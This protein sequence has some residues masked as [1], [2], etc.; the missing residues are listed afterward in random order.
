MEAVVRGKQWPQNY[1]S[2]AREGISSE[3]KR[4]LFMTVECGRRW[5][6][7]Q[8]MWTLQNSDFLLIREHNG[9]INTSEGEVSSSHRGVND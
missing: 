3:N 2:L 1:S 5:A 7:P 4:M 8:D 6:K 9:N